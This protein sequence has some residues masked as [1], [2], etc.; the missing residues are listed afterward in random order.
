MVN[1][2]ELESYLN[3]KSGTEGDLVEIMGEGLMGEKTDESGKV[4]KV[5]DIPV[6]LNG[7]LK[8]T[9]TPGKK[10]LN[11]LQSAWGKETK[12]WVGK[13]FQIK[14]VVMQI[15]NKEINVIKPVPIKA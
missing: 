11:E 1:T 7:Q 13:K 9:Y 12:Q 8:L 14:F 5:L 4:K 6:T 10:A 3:D 15:G 2:G